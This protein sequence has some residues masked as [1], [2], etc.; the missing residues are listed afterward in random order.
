MSN[1]YRLQTITSKSHIGEYCLKNKIV[2]IG[3]SL[4]GLE[5]VLRSDIKNDY[6]KYCVYAENYYNSYD[7]VNRLAN[8]SEN[9]LIWMRHEGLYYL[10]RVTAA[11]EWSFNNSAE[12]SLLDACNQVS[13]IEWI[14]IGAGDEGTVPG[15]VCTAF[16][17]GSTFQRI[18]K[19]G[20]REYSKIIYDYYSGVIHYS[21]EETSTSYN[22]ENFYNYISPDECEDLLYFYLYNKYGYV[23]IPST[24]KL[25]TQKY[26]MV[27]LDPNS[28]NHIYMQVKK[29]KV[30]LYA[31][32]YEELIKDG[33]EVWLLTT[34]GKIYNNHF[35]EK[36]KEVDPKMLFE[37]VNGNDP[38]V[39]IPPSII[40]WI[41][42]MN[43]SL[44][45]QKAVK[46]IILTQT[47]HIV[48]L[49]KKK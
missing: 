40:N 48:K 20:I 47:K 4:L 5:E 25:G 26:E 28:K 32:E 27:L 24:N 39:I 7:S 34:E 44:K 1:V 19:P 10:G 13:N 11:S 8:L 16:I 15:A 23:C 42:V 31:N 33:S 38:N 36:I 21:D 12:A 46:G 6:R 37:Y 2:A 9:D 14:K 49:I 35:P 41:E 45:K 30:D 43:G 29:G 3:W 17:K 18:N 22:M